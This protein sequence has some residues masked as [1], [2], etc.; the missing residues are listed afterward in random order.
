MP[1]PHGWGPIQL[2]V[3]TGLLIGSELAGAASMAQSPDCTMSLGAR[4]ARPGLLIQ[5]PKSHTLFKESDKDLLES[6]LETK[7]GEKKMKKID[8]SDDRLQAY[9]EL[10]DETG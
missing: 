2:H 9:V 5:H 6:R 10:E 3:I 4:D 7:I 1:R 8:F